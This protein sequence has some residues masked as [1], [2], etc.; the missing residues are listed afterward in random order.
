LVLAKARDASGIPSS[1]R[2]QRRD[3]LGDPLLGFGSPARYVPQPPP[4]AS[5]SKAPLLGFVIPY[6]ASGG[7]S[8]R[9]V[10]GR[11]GCA[12]V[13][14]GESHLR[15]LRC[16]PQAFSASRRPCSSL[17]RSAIFRRV[18]SLGFALQGLVPPTKPRRLIVPGIP[19]GR[20]SRRLACPHPRRG[21]L[22]A[23]WL[24][25][26]MVQPAP[27]FAFR[28]FVL[29]GIG[30]HHQ[31]TINPPVIDLPLLSLRL[32]MVCTSATGAR[33][34]P[35]RPSRFTD[36]RSVARPTSHCAPRLALY[37]S[38]PS[39]AR[40][41]SHLKVSRLRPTALFG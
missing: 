13:S 20:S 40:E 26:R 19:S 18:A 32:L 28:V 15:R 31:A 2:A 12:G 17:R 25:P 5:Q 29:V 27:F 36:G 11:P 10:S 6:D 41:P 4:S 14:A 1:T 7:E 9:P 23:C 16:R 22:R 30:P 33:L 34:P 38:G 37:R 39:L 21:R 35:P 24:L 8:P 3:S